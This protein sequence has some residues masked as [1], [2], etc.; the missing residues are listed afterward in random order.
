MAPSGWTPASL[1]V[2]V[3]DDALVTRLRH[4]L[5]DAEERNRRLL[6]VFDAM[7]EG[8]LL[9]DVLFNE[10]GRAVDIAYVEANPAAIR[11]VGMDPTGRRLRD[12]SADYE[13][14]WYDIWGHVAV[15]G[16]DER[17]ER[18]VLP[19]GAWYDYFLFKPR[20]EDRESRRVA[21]LFQNAS[22]RKT[23]ELA[24]HGSEERLQMLVAEL[25]HRVRNILTVVR[26][27]FSRTIEAGGELEDVAN[28]FR[29][30]LDNLARTQ[31]VV[32]QSVSG[33]VD[34]E[35]LIRDEL[36]SAGMG[37]GPCLSI[38]G[39][40]VPLTA[41]MAES[42]GLAVHELTTNAL[43][44]GALKIPGARLDIS[45]TVD[46]VYG[47]AR[48]LDFRWEE[49]GVPAVPLRPTRRGFGSELIEEALPYRLGAETRLEFRGGGVRC[50][51]SVPLSD[52]RAGTAWKGTSP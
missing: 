43:K 48:R 45:W 28:H 2:I 36:L 22:T 52:E 7:D 10:A 6:S 21:V 12:L 31:T 13:D 9:A 3:A 38:Q 19:E 34:L 39:P 27:V 15:T 25:Q 26:S 14:H 47:G 1:R 44:Y 50:A 18:Y 17:L 51:L 33:L 35:N 41:A 30:R 4:Q 23:A 49:H 37:D 11:M 8:Y 42:I 20:P 32:T 46:L 16:R 24:L 5:A 40:E 29:G